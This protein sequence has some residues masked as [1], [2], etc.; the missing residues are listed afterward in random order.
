M[1]RIASRNPIDNKKEKKMLMG[2]ITSDKVCNQLLPIISKNKNFKLPYFNTIVKWVN[3]FYN[4]YEKAPGPIIEDLFESNK[5]KLNDE[6][7]KLIHLFLTN[8]SQEHEYD[9]NTNEEY[10]VS[11]SIE[12]IDELSIG[13]LAEN[14]VD[15]TKVGRIE[16]AKQMIANF[17]GTMKLTSGWI[18]PFDPSEINNS[19]L[20]D[21]DVLFRFPGK[22]GEL[23][24]DFLRG[25]FIAYLAPYKSGKTFFLIELA[26]IA[27]N[28]GL[29]VLFVSLEMDKKRMNRRIYKRI[30]SCSEEGGPIKYPCFDCKLNQDNSCKMKERTN[31]TKLITDIG[32][33]P[34]FDPKLIYRPCTWCRDN[35]NKN[36]QLETWYTSIHRP[37]FNIKNIRE[38]VK[39]LGSSFDL[40]NLRTKSYPRF[41][42]GID[43]LETDMNIL[44]DTEDFH[45][46]VILTDYIDIF[47]KGNKEFRH[48][49]DELW[50]THARWATEY[51]CLVGTVTQSN[52]ESWKKKTVDASHT[53][54]NYRNPAHVDKFFTLSQTPLE[55]EKMFMRIMMAAARDENF[56]SNKAVAVL[57]NYNVGQPNID[58]EFVP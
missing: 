37:E 57:Q 34:E 6:E 55:K 18:N 35:N 51:K 42:I 4:L 13:N 26:T 27:L 17:R 40:Q 3:D 43:Q 2:L 54:E 39:A 21:D 29:K 1:S 45:P 48:A 46:D 32:G 7:I 16:E 49:I 41:S 28:F 53:S 22:L 50:M 19:M 56:D 47:Q 44:I 8:L 14:L 5:R 20:Y 38:Q 25:H 9:Y 36:Y 58:S 23:S 24:G 30:T 52:K 11:S 10:L 15:L 33:V 12:Y 31:K